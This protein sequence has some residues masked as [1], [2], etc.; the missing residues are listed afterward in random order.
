LAIDTSIVV[1][2]LDLLAILDL[3]EIEKTWDVIALQLSFL[4]ALSSGPRALRTSGALEIM[5]LLR[6]GIIHQRRAPAVSG[7]R[8]ADDLWH[9]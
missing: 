3:I 8:S 4:S 2:G 9:S 7:S 6:L 5:F 1:D